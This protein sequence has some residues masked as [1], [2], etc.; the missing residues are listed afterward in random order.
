MT[1]ARVATYN[2]PPRY[3]VPRLAGDVRNFARGRHSA[4]VV[5]LQEVPDDAVGHLQPSGFSRH[6]PDAERSS[7]LYWERNL[8]RCHERGMWRLSSEDFPNRFVVWA[9][10][11]HKISGDL[12]KFGAVQLIAFKTRDDRH[13]HEFT[14][15]ADR[16][17]EWLDRAGKRCAMGDVNASPGSA[18]LQ[19]VDAV[20]RA[21]KPETRSGP[22][23]QPIDVIYTNHGLPQARF[24]KT[25]GGASDHKA[26][27][28]IIPLRGERE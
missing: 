27:T 4:S 2:A 6:R 16:L 20:A 8:W 22:A 10:L 28:A 3:G 13:G 9:L 23:G 18:W 26:V 1:S 5:A 25:I 17:A 11:E 7:V 14:R 19:P 24:A 21:H 12:I 15:Q